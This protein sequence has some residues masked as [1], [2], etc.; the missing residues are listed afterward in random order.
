MMIRDIIL[1]LESHG[2]HT[3]G[4]Q[5]STS[6]SWIVYLDV[7]RTALVIYKLAMWGV[8]EYYIREYLDTHGWTFHE[9]VTIN[10]RIYSLSLISYMWSGDI[11][12]TALYLMHNEHYSSTELYELLGL[13]STNINTAKLM[14]KLYDMSVIHEILSAKKEY[15]ETESFLVYYH[16][17]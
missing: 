6:Y 15:T 5:E 14:D 12:Q 17:Y 10:N 2:I 13:K 11:K 8:Y 1:E 4:V 7:D 9:S 3:L 16:D